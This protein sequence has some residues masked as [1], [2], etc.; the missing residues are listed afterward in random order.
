[1]ISAGSSTVKHK[2]R[3]MPASIVAVLNPRLTSGL[4]S[5]RPWRTAL[6]RTI[7]AGISSNFSVG[8]IGSI[9]LQRVVLGRQVVQTTANVALEII[10]SLAQIR[11][12]FGLSMGIPLLK[13]V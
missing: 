5:R 13:F 10:A 12:D 7:T 9:G 11:I 3:E 1:M 8:G 2:K 6:A 4:G